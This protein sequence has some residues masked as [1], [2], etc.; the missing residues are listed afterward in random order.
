MIESA[1]CITV[2]IVDVEGVRVVRKVPPERTHRGHASR[3][4]VH[5][6]FRHVRLEYLGTCNHKLLKDDLRGGAV[7]PNLVLP[8]GALG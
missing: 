1:G 4:H 5:G 3:R 6:Q 7:A 2:L 8:T